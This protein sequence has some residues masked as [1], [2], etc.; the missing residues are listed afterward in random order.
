MAFKSWNSNKRKMQLVSLIDMVFILLVFF[1][2]TIFI[3]REP[4]EEMRLAVP[5]P[6]NKPGRAQILIQL[7]P[8][9][10]FFMIDES[11]MPVV[12]S[13]FR[14]VENRFG[15]LSVQ[16]LQ[17]KKKEVVFRTLTERF[18]YPAEQLSHKIQQLLNKANRSPNEKYFVL[19]RC[20]DEVPYARVIEV[21]EKLSQAQYNNVIYGCVGGSLE[22]IRNCKQIRIVTEIDEKGIKRDNLWI[23]F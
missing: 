15:Y 19:I 13:V 7:L 1:L 18:T 21:I 3:V 23:T 10:E 12:E 6:E 16:N 4:R 17:Q 8:S 11:A 20:P 5:T 22:E 2:V 9:D 14:D